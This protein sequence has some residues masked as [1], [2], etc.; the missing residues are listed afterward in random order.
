[1]GEYHSL[2]RRQL[3]R[4]FG[5]PDAVPPE[6]RPLLDAVDEAYRE[7]DADRALLE[8]SLD[9]S[10]Q[11][12]L[13]ANADMV[14]LFR[15]VP[16]RFYRL[17]AAGRII[18][19]RGGRAD[20]GE[21]PVVGRQFQDLLPPA[22]VPDFEAALAR[23]RRERAIARFEY[24][25]TDAV[26]ASWEARV[27]PLVDDQVIVI[28][29]DISDRRRAEAGIAALARIGREVAA[30]LDLERVAQQICHAV[31]VLFQVRRSALY[32]LDPASGALVCI[33]SAG[34]VDP[35]QWVGQVLPLGEGVAGLAASRRRVVWSADFLDDP[36]IAVPAWARE[37]AEAEAFRSVMAV[38][39]V[40]RDRVI[41]ALA[42]A[43]SAGRAYTYDERQLLAGLGDQ[44]AIAI[45]NAR[46]FEESERRRR[47]A[48]AL[49]ELGR[50]VSASLE[51]GE[52]AEKVVHALHRLLPCRMMVLYRVEPDTGDLALVAGVGSAV[53]WNRRLARGT[54]TVGRA[55]RERQPVVTADVLSDP[56]ITLAPEA[57]ARIERSGYRAV[58]AVP[59]LARD[60]VIGGLA[61]G[62]VLGRV[63]DAEDV[64][65]VQTFADQA[66]I[67][68]AN[69]EL[70]AQTRTRLV[71]M[72]RLAELSHLVSSSTDLQHVLDSVT[73]ASLELLHGDLARLWV[74]DRDAGRLRLVAFYAADGVTTAELTTRELPLH[75]G[76]VGWVMREKARRYSPS[77]AEDPLQLH[78]GWVRRLGYV[79]QLAVPLMAGEEAVG[80]LLVITKTAR[81]FTEEEVELLDVFAAKAA[82]AVTNA[83]LYQEA[84]EA[85]DQL[86]KAQ[87]MLAHSQKMEAVGR[88][89]GGVAHD[90]NNILTIITGRCEAMLEALPAG[91]P[92]QAE[93]ELIANAADRAAALTRQLLAFSRRQALERRVVDLNVVVMGMVKMLRRLIGE[94]I[95]LGTS[96]A[97]DPGYVRA[98]SGQIEQV[99]LNL[100]VNARDAM[101]EGGRLTIATAGVTIEGEVE[102]ADG[103]V[104]PGAYV[105]LSVGDSGQ[106]IDAETRRRLF[107][108]FFTTKQVGRG[109]GLGLAT[110]YGIIRQ[111]DAH[112]AVE[113]A[114][115]HGASFIIYFP[116]VEAEE[117]AGP[118]RLPRGAPGP[119]G[120]ETIL[121]VEDEPQVRGLVRQV[122]ESH[123][124]QVLDAGGG[125]DA[126]RVASAFPDRIHLLVTDLVMPGMSG[127]A[128]AETMRR[129]RPATRTLYISGY[130]DDVVGRVSELE[131]PDSAF[132]EKPF[133]NRAF[134]IKVREL[135]DRP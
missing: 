27:A 35:A 1:M 104:V 41:G 128:V 90:F 134:A 30:T 78:T 26:D 66:A 103:Q 65:L 76:L 132:I 127:R 81:I 40:T 75:E 9:L 70:Y 6:I 114:P 28:V 55:V 57:R 122:L 92:R 4:V 31:V 51:P 24:V 20:E 117:P 118:G 21:R 105:T 13:Q 125:A 8:R 67:A 47:A 106:G 59:L 54:A 91:D 45:E 46:L 25:A 12:L 102:A 33:A 107:E 37:R 79:S 18:D 73:E 49:A 44:A 133:T 131:G 82:T 84:R 38:P 113:S 99:L 68:L 71:R 61:V 52:V 110:V 87:E 109:S 101:P 36:A 2:L 48:E 112:I 60:R 93:L 42:L 53:D 22:A 10:S 89:A 63:F 23:V 3:R 11:E 115:G 100:A 124:Y 129:L 77:L 94:N 16:D 69:A 34:G 86:S 130:T 15:A 97:P 29:R 14:A 108:P 72:R 19:H 50:L 123:G 32:R 121:L 7:S 17:D 116:R 98:D 62:D 135:L 58:L 64:R 95:E 43:D 80:A 5:H 120:S 88:L 56:A 74:L 126:L 39:L 119:S 96:L 111:H 83:R 85:Y